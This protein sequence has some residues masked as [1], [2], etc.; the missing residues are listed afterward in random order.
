MPRLCSAFSG[1]TADKIRLARKEDLAKE[2]FTED[3]SNF[4]QKVLPNKNSPAKAE[5][6]LLKVS[7]RCPNLNQENLTAGSPRFF[8]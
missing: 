5:L 6:F 8:Y 4:V 2:G 3:L 1:T 7:A